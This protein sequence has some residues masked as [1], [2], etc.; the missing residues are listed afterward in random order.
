MQSDEWKG[1]HRG[2]LPVLLEKKINIHIQGNGI[3]VSQ[4][5]PTGGAWTEAQQLFAALQYQGGCQNT[6]MGQSEKRRHYRSPWHQRL[7]LQIILWEKNPIDCPFY[8]D[9]IDISLSMFSLL[10]FRGV[11]VSAGCRQ[12]GWVVFNSHSWWLS[13]LCLECLPYPLSEDLYTMHTIYTPC[14]VNNE[15][16]KP[17]QVSRKFIQKVDRF[18]NWFDSIES[19]LQELQCSCEWMEAVADLVE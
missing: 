10:L 16:P 5:W 13:C 19:D 12:E 3:S 18:A 17:S 8:T 11:V 9:I 1:M 7:E 2:L 4:P 6:T 15:K 14:P